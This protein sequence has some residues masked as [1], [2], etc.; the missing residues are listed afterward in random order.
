[1]EPPRNIS[2]GHRFSAFGAAAGR[3]RAG[4]A[5]T[6]AAARNGHLAEL[7]ASAPDLERALESLRARIAEHYGRLSGPPC[8]P[9]ECLH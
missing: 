2:A 6:A 1:S 8:M 9:P 7:A 5:S 3:R 4:A